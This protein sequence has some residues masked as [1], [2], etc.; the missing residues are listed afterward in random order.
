M[1]ETR[2]NPLWI[3]TLLILVAVATA[4]P[5]DQE[6]L[7]DKKEKK[8]PQALPAVVAEV[9]AAIKAADTMALAEA[10]KRAHDL[11][12][13]VSAE[14][15]EPLV[16][17]FAKGAKH[18]QGGVALLCIK[19]IGE[20]EY[21]GASRYVQ[22]LLSPPKNPKENRYRLHLAAIAAA[23]SLHETASLRSLEN[24]VQHPTTE[25]AVASTKALAR[26]SVVERKTRLG[27][28]RRL[29]D[30]LGRLEAKRAKTA[31]AK[32]H[33]ATV[34]ESLR[35]CLRKLTSE[36]SIETAADARKWLRKEQTGPK[37]MP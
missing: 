10:C 4:A 3:P 29:A 30:S 18:K 23:G 31:V 8:G 37:P 20:S 26:Y 17:A 5:E 28:I 2:R 24:L 25:L 36:L 12:A 22:F 13:D 35:D 15:Y 14:Q 6:K 11:R 7:A 33:V 21:P 19:A 1:R 34:R 32:Q 27:L 16:R 9:Q